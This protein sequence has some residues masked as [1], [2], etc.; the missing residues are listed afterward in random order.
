LIPIG[1]K[2][3]SKFKMSKGILSREHIIASSVAVFNT[4][5]YE[6]TSMS[7]LIE[8]TGFQKGGIYRHFESKEQLAAEA[9]QYAYAQMK[10]A[11]SG[12]YDS[13]DAPEVKLIKFLTRMKEFMIK[14]PVKGGCPILNLSTEVD[15]TNDLLR[16]LVKTAATEWETMMVKIFEEGKQMKKFHKKIDAVMEARFLISSIEGAIMLSKLHRDPS[17]GYA[18]ADLLIERVGHLKK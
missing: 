17:Y 14:P 13:A 5:G 12:T 15:D 18:I 4:K 11:Y 9:F 3:K 2:I 16:K 10:K 8:K 1:L 6:G 7:D